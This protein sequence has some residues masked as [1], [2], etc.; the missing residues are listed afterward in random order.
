M[1]G[2]Y[3]QLFLCLNI[4]ILY[5]TGFLSGVKMSWRK[6]LIMP[7]ERAFD[8][9]LSTAEF[10]RRMSRQTLCYG[11]DVW[12]SVPAR[13]LSEI[14]TQ[15]VND[16]LQSRHKPT[17]RTIITRNS[18]AWYKCSDISEIWAWRCSELKIRH[19]VTE[20]DR[21]IRRVFR[22]RESKSSRCWYPQIQWL[23]S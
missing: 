17:S 11:G 14:T 13:S 5:R 3:I 23:L 7:I 1:R 16:W 15:Q 6:M 19:I 18:A 12:T 10:T 2:F 22:T 9:Y 20:R 21:A 4:N 8:E